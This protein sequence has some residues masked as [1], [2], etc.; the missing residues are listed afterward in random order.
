MGRASYKIQREPVKRKPIG[1]EDGASVHKCV[2]VV[3]YFFAGR[4]LCIVP[5]DLEQSPS[6]YRSKAVKYS[7]HEDVVISIV[8]AM[9]VWI[10]HHQWSRI[11][12]HAR[13]LSLNRYFMKLFAPQPHP[14]LIQLFPQDVVVRPERFD[15]FPD[16]LELYR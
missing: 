4:A 6:L 11:C 5:D 9:K 15:H 3:F 1:H 8:F 2:E 10:N 14:D 12:Q 13:S 7:S 16:G